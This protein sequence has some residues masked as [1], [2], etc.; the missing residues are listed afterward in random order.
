MTFTQYTNAE[1]FHELRLN[2]G[3]FLRKDSDPVYRGDSESLLVERSLIH[4]MSRVQQVRYPGDVMNKVVSVNSEGGAGLTSIEY[5]T[6]DLTGEFQRISTQATNIPEVNAKMTP[7]PNPVGIFAASYGYT[8]FDLERADRGGVSLDE[9]KGRALMLA[10][11][12]KLNSIYWF[13]DGD[14]KGLFN[15]E[16]NPVTIAGAWDTASPAEIL[17]DCLEVINQVDITTEDFYANTLVVSPYVHSKI[18]TTRLGDGTDTTVAQFIFKNTEIDRIVK[19]SYLNDV[20]NSENSLTNA[21]VMMAYY[22]DPIILEFMLPRPLQQDPMY[23][24][25]LQYNIPAVFDCA[26]TFVYHPKSIAFAEVTA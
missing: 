20:T 19:T 12:K 6:L 3:P 1:R 4:V 25:G 23:R 7:T 14:I 5:N 16:L 15:Y 21:Q 9:R 11:R 24:M 8:K 26:G 13:G 17:A 10:A 18:Y 2:L 22:R